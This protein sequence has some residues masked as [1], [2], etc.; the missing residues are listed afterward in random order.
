MDRASHSNKIRKG[1]AKT[2]AN[3]TRLGRKPVSTAVV[4]QIIEHREAGMG[5]LK[6]G[7]TLGIGTSVVQRVV[8]EAKRQD[9]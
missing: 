6:I 9:Y 2:K 5:I 1:L 4:R 7:K 3:G 8:L